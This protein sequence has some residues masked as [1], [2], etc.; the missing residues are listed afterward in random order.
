LFLRPLIAYVSATVIASRVD[1]AE[2]DMTLQGLQAHLQREYKVELGM[3]SHGVSILFSSFMNPKKLK[4]RKPMKV[5]T[6]NSRQQNTDNK[7]G[8]AHTML[9]L[10]QI[11]E[12][13]ESITKRTIPPEQKYLIFELIVN[14]TETGD[15]V[16]FPYLRF[17]LH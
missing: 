12:I 14:D 16:E 11:K 2:P 13:V 8:P 17:K 3:L 6:R 7:T 1:I 10:S 5:R 4:E 9:A 15:E